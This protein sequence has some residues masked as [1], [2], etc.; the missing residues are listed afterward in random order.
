MRVARIASGPRDTL[1][2]TKLRQVNVDGVPTRYY[3]EGS[4]DPL[5]LLHGGHP[6]FID[7]L[8]TWSLNLKGL[9]QHFRVYALDKI[10]QGFTG[11]PS[12]DEDYTQDVT[13]R[14]AIR[15]MEILDIR[16]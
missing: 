2:Q 6:G 5:V 10:G 1:D 11:N 13:T 16:S 9:A 4:G 12:R 3:D 14:H 8:D 7:S 15:W